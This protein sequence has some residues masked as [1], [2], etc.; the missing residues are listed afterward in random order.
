[1]EF[2][3]PSTLGMQARASVRGERGSGKAGEIEDDGQEQDFA[4]E[5]QGVSASPMVVQ[6]KD[7]PAGNGDQTQDKKRIGNIAIHK[8]RIDKV[9]EHI[10]RSLVVANYVF[11]GPHA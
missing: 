10:G 7:E 4:R 5:R 6:P 2:N 1:M 9:A 11:S 8:K 3:P